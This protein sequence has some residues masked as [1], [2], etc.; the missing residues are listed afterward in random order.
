MCMYQKAC[1]GFNV[2]PIY[3]DTLQIKNQNKIQ[4][5]VIVSHDK[6]EKKSNTCY[7]S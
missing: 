5:Y 3:M 1:V 4:H 6:S 7:Y 2:F